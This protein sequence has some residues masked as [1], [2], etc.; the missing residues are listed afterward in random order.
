MEGKLAATE[1]GVLEAL[2]VETFLGDF[3]VT[4]A[5]LSNKL[6]FEGDK[7]FLAV[8]LFLGV[9]GFV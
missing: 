1:L 9:G 6:R 4:T 5:V 2:G 7:G 8:S 3:G